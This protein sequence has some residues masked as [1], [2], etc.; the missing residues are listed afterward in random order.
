MLALA[1]AASALLA[2]VAVR[3]AL[4]V[5]PGA[6]AG[7]N[8][9]VSSVVALSPQTALDNLSLAL[10]T[11]GPVPLV[12]ALLGAF[13]LRAAAWGP[14]A[15]FPIAIAVLPLFTPVPSGSDHLRTLAT[16]VVAQ[17]WLAAIGLKE[18]VLALGNTVPRRVGA[19]ALFLAVALLQWSHRSPPRTLQVDTPVGH[20]DLTRRAVARLLGVLPDRASLVVDDAITDLLLR[21]SMDSLARSGKTLQFVAA[22]GEAVTGLAARGRVFAL[23]RAQQVLQHQGLILDDHDLPQAPGVAGIQPG[24]ACARAEASWRPI[25]DPQRW[26]TLALV[27][28]RAAVR[29]PILVYLGSAAPLAPHPLQWP[30]RATRGFLAD[31]YYARGDRRRLD[32]LIGADR[33]PGGDPVFT[34]PYVT[35]LELWRVPDAPL[36]LPVSLGGAVSSAIV[37]VRAG[38]DAGQLRACPSFPRAVSRV[39]QRP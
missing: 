25:A 22:D 12:L 26:T 8:C 31:V 20:E 19:G 4:P 10:S 30:D 28:D 5:L 13:T 32:W 33:A 18:A 27:S 6:P 21:A 15:W 39:G 7:N 23:P 3:A 11:T 29:G 17:W 24:V 9:G 36:I 34:S 16:T 1:A 2:V 14:R 38:P 37:I 35:R